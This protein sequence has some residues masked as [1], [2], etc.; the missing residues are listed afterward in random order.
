MCVVVTPMNAMA[1]RRKPGKPVD[2]PVRPCPE[3]ESDIPVTARR[4]AFCTAEVGKGT[5]PGAAVA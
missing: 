1:A 4:C 3:C 2:K 5:P